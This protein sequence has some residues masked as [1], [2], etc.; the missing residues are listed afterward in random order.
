MFIHRTPTRKRSQGVPFTP[1]TR[2]TRFILM[3]VK[4]TRYISQ[5][6]ARRTA[7]LSSHL[8]CILSDEASRSD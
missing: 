8:A 3:L 6:F 1:R 4:F 5:R 2:N 7:A